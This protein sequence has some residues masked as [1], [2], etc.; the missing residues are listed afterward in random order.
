MCSAFLVNF[1]AG[2]REDARRERRLAG[3]GGGVRFAPHVPRD[4]L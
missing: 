4:L 3:M 1:G 2:G